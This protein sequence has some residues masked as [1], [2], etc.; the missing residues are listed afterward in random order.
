[1]REIT[2]M[3]FTLDWTH[4]SSSQRKAIIIHSLSSQFLPP[5]PPLP[6]HFPSF[7]STFCSF[8]PDFF[9]AY[10]DLS[11]L[12]SLL[13][14][15]PL[16]LGFSLSFMHQCILLLRSQASC[17]CVWSIRYLTSVPLKMTDVSMNRRLD[18]LIFKKMHSI[19]L[20]MQQQGKK[21]KKHLSVIYFISHKYNKSNLSVKT[22]SYL[23]VSKIIRKALRESNN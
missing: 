20:F 9:S 3:L 2:V 5:L 13:L 11:N 4:S 1:M 8:W 21:I 18:V 6:S 12:F 16:S 7:A 22:L 15:L 17:I 23:H 14:F 10:I 19:Y